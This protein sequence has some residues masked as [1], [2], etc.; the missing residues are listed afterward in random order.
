MYRRI[1]NKYKKFNPYNQLDNY[2]IKWTIIVL[3]VSIFCSMLKI[4][5]II[6]LPVS[7]VVFI[8]QMIRYMINDFNKYAPT[9]EGKKIK[10]K[11]RINIY[12]DQID[13]VNMEN[14][15]KLLNEESISNKNDI[16]LLINHYNQKVPITIKSSI[17]DII[18]SVSLTIASFIV[19]FVDVESKSINYDVLLS[20]L[21]STLG[22]ILFILPV[23]FIGKFFVNIWTP[24]D[25]VYLELKEKLTYIYANYKK[26]EY[27]LKKKSQ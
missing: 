23:F 22:I 16:L 14:L 11:E 1:E 17:T 4:K 19:L 5:N 24:K 10:I 8:V 13:Y 12:L 9:E 3:I 15:I 27:Q 7:M 18:S 21:G 6:I 26:Y 25:S 20:V 2:Y